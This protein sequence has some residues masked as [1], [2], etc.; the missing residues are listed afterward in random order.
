M[1]GLFKK[2]KQETP[3]P[4]PAPQP[5]QDKTPAFLRPLYPYRAVGEALDQTRLDDASY[6]EMEGVLYELKCPNP[7]CVLNIRTQGV[8]VKQ[9]YDQ[10]RNVSGCPACKLQFGE[11]DIKGY[12]FKEGEIPHEVPKNN[13]RWDGF[14]VRRVIHV[15]DDI[16]EQYSQKMYGKPKEE[17][18]RA[19]S[20]AL[21]EE[22]YK[23]GEWKPREAADRV[24]IA[25]EKAKAEAARAAAAA[26]RAKAEAEKAQEPATEQQAPT[27]EAKA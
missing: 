14:I 20:D 15:D 4:E 17:M 22:Y 1:F 16:F 3:A 9:V 2:K 24:R 19:E 18:T 10:V 12:T 25:E 13:N 21:C 27:P 26:E 6:L 23:S 5:P 7:E 11:N 8:N